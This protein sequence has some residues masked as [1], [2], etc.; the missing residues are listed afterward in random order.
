MPLLDLTVNREEPMSKRI[1]L[2]ELKNKNIFPLRVEYM[3]GCPTP[4]GYANGW[5]IEITEE[6]EEIIYDLDNSCEVTQ[7]MEFD[8]LDQVLLWIASLPIVIS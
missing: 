8:N 3:R 6:L 2:S 7:T 1:I 4:Y 5:E